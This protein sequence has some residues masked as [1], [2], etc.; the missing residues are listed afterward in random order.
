MKLV[1][2]AETSGTNATSS[3]NVEL[4]DFVRQAAELVFTM[5]LSLSVAVSGLP[6]P[7]GAKAM[8]QQENA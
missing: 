3:Q 2:F 4:F 1:L 8:N 7:N 5:S 6:V